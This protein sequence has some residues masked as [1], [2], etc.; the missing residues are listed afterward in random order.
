MGFTPFGSENGT[1]GSGVYHEVSSGQL[2]GRWSIVQGGFLGG[3]LPPHLDLGRGL[4][5]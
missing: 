5:A 1:A 4:L 2:S 3:G